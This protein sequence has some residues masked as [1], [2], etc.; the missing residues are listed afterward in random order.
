MKVSKHLPALGPGWFTVSTLLD[1]WT[2]YELLH[3]SHTSASNLCWNH[4]SDQF[5][6]HKELPFERK[7]ESPQSCVNYCEECNIRICSTRG[8]AKE[9]QDHKFFE[10]IKKNRPQQKFITKG[11]TYSILEKFISP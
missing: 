10:T 9:Y 1:P 5:K 7:K 11:F 8:S 3:L 6:E 4:I 2:P